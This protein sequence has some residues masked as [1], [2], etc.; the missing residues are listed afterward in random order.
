MIIKKINIK[1]FLTLILSLFDSS[2]TFSIRIHYQ[3]KDY[4]RKIRPNYCILTYEGY[5]WER[6]CIN[7]VKKVNKK[8]KCI[9]YQHT[10]VTQNHRAIFNH[11]SGNFNPDKIWCSEIKSFQILKKKIHAKMKKNVYFIGNFKKIVGEKFKPPKSKNSFLVIPEGIYSECESLFKFSLILARRF[12][13]YNF[14]W[15]VHP[16]IDFN[17]VLKNLK[18]NKTELPKNISIS[19]KKFEEDIFRSKYVIYKG[20]AAAIKSVVMGNYP[21]YFNSFNEKNFDPIIQIFKRRN[22]VSNE[23]NF[24]V[25]LKKTRN[26]NY[27][28]EF[29]KSILSLKNI[30]FSKPDLRKIKSHLLK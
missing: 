22:Y 27:K 30:Y 5:P 12:Q 6:M 20:S 21:I 23:K 29:K 10:P 15:R 18:L 19:L 11:M 9:G 16:V 26:K 3:I 24:L 4:V 28:N 2:T 25:F 1:E 8:T 7:G 14:I 17:K 13:E